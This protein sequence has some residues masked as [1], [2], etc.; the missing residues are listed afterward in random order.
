MGRKDNPLLDRKAE[1]QVEGLTGKCRHQ[2]E[3]AEAGGARSAFAHIVKLP[4]QA[5]AR[6]R[7]VHEECANPRGLGP[8][9]EAWITPVLR[10]I[11]AVERATTAPAA[12]CGRARIAVD[13]VVRPVSMS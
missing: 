10:L 7:G 3:L 13:D 8:R 2:L 5:A 11:T 6:M 9:I 1:R 12:G 4:R